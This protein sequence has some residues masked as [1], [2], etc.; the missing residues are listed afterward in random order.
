MQRLVG[1]AIGTCGDANVT[2]QCHVEYFRQAVAAAF[3]QLFHVSYA[4]PYAG[5]LL[6]RTAFLQ[7]VVLAL[8]TQSYGSGCC[9]S[10]MCKFKLTPVLQARGR[11]CELA[12]CAAAG[13]ALACLAS[14]SAHCIVRRSGANPLLPFNVTARYEGKQHRAELQ[15]RLTPALTVAAWA[16]RGARAA[17]A[18][19]VAA[20]AAAMVQTQ[21]ARGPL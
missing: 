11:A 5:Q 7:A 15:P 21:V 16:A 8:F 13:C 3:V 18:V 9:C 10:H 19:V 17:A 2:K 20:A 4:L 6:A 12:R 1:D 14:L